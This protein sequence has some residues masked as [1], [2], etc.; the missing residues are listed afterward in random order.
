[1]VLKRKRSVSEFSSPTHSTTSTFQCSSPIAFGLNPFASSPMANPHHLPSRTL[2]RSRDSRP[3]DDEVHRKFYE[4]RAHHRSGSS[5]SPVADPERTLD[6][7]FSAAQRQPPSAGAH[8]P[9]VDYSMTT[10]QAHDASFPSPAAAPMP[11]HDAS[12]RSLH[13]FWAISSAPSFAASTPPLGGDVMSTMRTATTCDDCGADLPGSESG[14][15]DM[16]VDGCGVDC[17]CGPCGKSVCGHCSVT[18][19]DGQRQCLQCAGRKVW[20]GG[21]GWTTPSDAIIF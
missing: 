7:L 9:H 4:W 15:M 12:Q 10:P 3:S 5:N 16:D 2:K 13:N 11:S 1:M 14:A 19:I 17:A 6:M 8:A 21:I 20:V 18:N